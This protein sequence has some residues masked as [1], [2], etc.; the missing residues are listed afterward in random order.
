[1]QRASSKFQSH[2]SVIEKAPKKLCDNSSTRPLQEVS[3]NEAKKPIHS[4]RPA[5]SKSNKSQA[6]QV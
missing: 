4:T 6:T 5:S 1:M 3:L 2:F